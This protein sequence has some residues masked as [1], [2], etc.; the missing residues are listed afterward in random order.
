MT[1]VSTQ[2]WASYISDFPDV[3]LLQTATWGDF[4]EAF[5]W[6]PVRII[7]EAGVQI[8]LRP[9]FFGL[10][11]AYIPKGPLQIHSLDESHPLVQEIDLFCKNNRVVFL[12]V[13]PDAWQEPNMPD[14]TPVYRLPSPSPKYRISSYAIQ[15]PRTLTIDLSGS[16]DTIL[17]RMKQKTRY[18]I[19]LS[20]KRGV[21]VHTYPDVGVFYD[22]LTITGQ[23]DLFGVHS[24]EYYHQCFHAFQQQDAC[25]LFIAEYDGSPLAGLLAFR[26]G[27]RAWYFYGA[28][29]NE[30]RELMPTYAIQWEAMRWAKE[31]GCIV[32]DLWG[33]PDQE[34]AILEQQFSSRSDGLWGVYRFKR[35]FGGNLCRSPGPWDRVYQPILYAFYRLWM[36]FRQRNTE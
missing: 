33:V 25:E 3:H 23:R 20:Q 18:N 6:K 17:E 2:E 26:W 12:K 7:Q 5:G 31:N 35:G 24:L 11:M 27:K 28:S 34:K 36:N 13:E 29:N 30:K 32:Y 1:I 10:S 14:P 8:L 15:P 22:L 19:K 16:Q 21:E 4:K 9:L